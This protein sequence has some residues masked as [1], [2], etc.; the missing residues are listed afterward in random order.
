MKLTISKNANINY[1]ARIVQVDTFHPHP[2]ADKLKLCTVEGYIISTGIDS[3]EGIYVYF[4][5]ECVINPKFLKYHNL[6]RKKELNQNPEQ[7]GFLKN[8]EELNVL[9][10]GDCFWRFYYAYKF[11]NFLYKR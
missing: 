9:N 2:N 4:P 10:S 5:V 7:S 3:V 1:L 8:Q 6:Y 11:L